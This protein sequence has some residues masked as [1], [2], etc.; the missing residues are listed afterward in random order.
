MQPPTS[1]SQNLMPRKRIALLSLLLLPL[2]LLAACH[3]KD[4]AQPSAP[5]PAT[6]RPTRPVADVDTGQQQLLVLPDD[7]ADVVLGLIDNAR[8]TIRFKIYLLTYREARTALVNAA[9]RGVDVRI[10]IDPDPVGGNESNIESYQMLES[11][12]VAV[13][14]SSDAFRHTHEKSLVIDDK[15]A[16]I[17]TFNFTHSSFTRNREYGLL[18]TGPDVVAEVAAIFDAD[19]N[20]KKPSLRQKS[21]LVL[22]PV[23]SRQRLTQ[24]IRSAQKTLILEEATLLDEDIT[25]ELVAV[26]K[27]GVAVTFLAP[28][29]DQNDVAA[30]NLKRLQ[31]AGAQVAHLKTPFIHAKIILADDRQAFIGSQNLTYTSLERSRELGIITTEAAVVARLRQQLAHDWQAAT[32]TM[33][34]Q[35]PS[36]GPVRSI[37]WQDAEAYAGQEVTVRG[38]IVHTYDSGK[39]TFLNFDKDYHNTLTLVLF[40]SIYAEFPAKPAQYFSNKEIE[41]IGRVKMYEGKPEIVIESSQQIKVLGD[42]PAPQA[43]APASI[44]AGP[45]PEIA[46]QEAGDYVGQQVIVSGEVVRSYNSGKV[47]FLNFD[48]DWRGKFSVVIFASDFTNFDAPPEQKYLH[49]AI[50]VTGKIKEYKGAPEIIVESPAQIEMVGAVATATPSS[51]ASGILSWQQA[52]AFVGQRVTVQGQIVRAK[53]IGTITF[54]N[55]SQKRGDFVL[56]V[57]AQDYPN[58]PQAPAQLYNGKKVWATGEISLYRGTPQMVLHSPQQIEVFE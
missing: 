5:A 2:L 27:R 52:G 51:I 34:G 43:R 18:S 56:I 44:P 25:Q 49:Q 10:I 9:R 26:A 16:L 24:L 6:V 57:R 40:P 38:V 48:E 54:L 58:F 41:V 4:A 29:R 42:G 55:F 21:P 45:L 14:W 13:R 19:W 53:D 35:P 15:I 47:A 50:R 12:G 20:D 11:A 8:D 32:G 39:V 7:G 28:Q 31:S 33:L 17:A 46:W 30:D 37:A 1:N 3:A 22:S 23:N 36:A